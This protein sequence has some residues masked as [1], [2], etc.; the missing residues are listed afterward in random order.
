LRVGIFGGSFNPVHRQHLTIAQAAR[1]SAD[2][3]QVWFIPVF[4]P[5]HKSREDF[6]DYEQR[7]E[8]LQ[9]AI[10]EVDGMQIVDVEKELGG[11]SY[12][13]RTVKHLQDRYPTY[14]FLLI[15]GGDSLN[16][17]ST[18]RSIDELVRL[19]EF[20]VV[21]R[22]GFSCES[23]VK[24]AVLHWAEAEL[25]PISSTDI[26]ARLKSH[27]FSDFSDL[28]PM[29]LYQILRNN[30]YGAAGNL[31]ARVLHRLNEYLMDMPSGLRV[32]V[33]GVAQ[34]AFLLALGAEIPLMQAII[35]GLAHDIF[36]IASFAHIQ[37]WAEKSGYHLSEIEKEVPMLAHG[38]AAA[39]LLRHEFPELSSELIEALRHH[40]LPEPDLSDLGKILVIADTL[41]PSRGI[42]ARN[43]LREIPLPLHEKFARVL[44]LKRDAAKSKL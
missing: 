25:S 7:R 4:D 31:F 11:A 44:Q 19:V 17:L 29:V 16:E 43:E 23:P 13:V 5:V 3:D 38:A 8:L 1:Q 21:E 30:Y 27:D 33:E 15:I 24:E 32:H 37:E 26:R 12:T 40:T 14:K 2:L 22:P 36:R 34:Q 39:G 10:A 9:L 6:L 20:I 28:P 35:A 18:W 42:P 41:E